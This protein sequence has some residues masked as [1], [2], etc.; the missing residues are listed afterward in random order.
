MIANQR[1]YWITRT[2]ARRIERAIREFHAFAPE[3]ADVHPRWLR[4]EGEGMESVPADLRRELGEHE[5]LGSANLGRI[6]TSSLAEFGDALDKARI[7]AG[8]SRKDLA[9]R[10]DLAQQQ[11]Q[12]YE[13]TRYAT[14]T[15]RRILFPPV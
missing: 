11:I 10:L 12:R 8:L 1:Q 2:Q 4:A 9:D 15:F 5:G 3:R 14:A 13:A 6:P 7:A